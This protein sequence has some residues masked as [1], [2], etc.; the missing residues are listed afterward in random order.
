MDPEGKD[1]LLSSRL[2]S[3]LSSLPPDTTVLCGAGPPVPASSRLLEATCPL[4]GRLLQEAGC[5]SCL[6][7]PSLTSQEFSSYLASCIALAFGVEGKWEEVKGIQQILSGAGAGAKTYV[8]AEE[9]KGWLG[10]DGCTAVTLVN[11]SVEKEQVEDRVE[12][13]F[14]EDDVVS[15]EDDDG[16]G[17]SGEVCGM[18]GFLQGGRMGSAE[19]II[20]DHK[21]TAPKIHFSSGKIILK[22]KVCDMCGFLSDKGT[23]SWNAHDMRC[24]PKQFICQD[25]G[26][27]S[28]NASKLKKH[29]WMQH[30]KK[31]SVVW[32]AVI[33]NLH[34]KDN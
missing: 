3:C 12:A 34:S 24:P 25:C 6:L 31:T 11:T 14:C 20:H 7:I 23:T 18:C 32:L 27:S 26:F 16:E 15:G 2:R 5:D 33:M 29:K 30:E 1:L 17:A 21:C 8:E 28:P 19:Q 13:F 22:L 10:Q 9:R 4:L